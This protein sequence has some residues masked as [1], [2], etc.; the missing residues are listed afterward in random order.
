MMWDFCSH[1]VPGVDESV[2]DLGPVKHVG[3]PRDAKNIHSSLAERE[4]D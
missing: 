3:D 2:R 1:K 4:L